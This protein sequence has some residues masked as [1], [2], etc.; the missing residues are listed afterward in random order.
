M[1]ASCS[2]PST[3]PNTAPLVGVRVRVRVSPDPNPNPNPITPT[4]NPNHERR[5]FA[6]ARALTAPPPLR[7]S[8]E[9]TMIEATVESAKRMT[10]PS[11]HRLEL[12][13]GWN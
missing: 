12:V 9:G 3:P 13:R 4:P 10:P 11:C 1:P 8:S 7:L 6:E 5:R 2:P